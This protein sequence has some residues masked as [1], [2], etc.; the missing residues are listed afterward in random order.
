MFESLTAESL[1][2]NL[3]AIVALGSFLYMKR[4]TLLEYY[5]HAPGIGKM[6]S[7]RDR[8]TKKKVLVVSS[9]Q[10]DMV[11][12]SYHSQIAAELD[13]WYF[14]KDVVERDEILTKEEYKRKYGDKKVH[15]L[16]RYGHH[17]ITPITHTSQTKNGVLCMGISSLTEFHVMVFRIENSPVVYHDLFLNFREGIDLLEEELPLDDATLEEDLPPPEDLRPEEEPLPESELPQPPPSVAQDN[18][19]G[20][21]LVE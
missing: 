1:A 3:S 13:F 4:Y 17:I 9:E 18:L 21:S 10:G 11:I 15:H 6:R 2:M 14:E 19:E 5:Y 20:L 16:Q 7:K 12:D 8:L